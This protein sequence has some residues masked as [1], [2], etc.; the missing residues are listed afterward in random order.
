MNY[1]PFHI[2]DYFS[3]TRHLSWE[4][5][6]A[7]RR[8]LDVYYRDERPIPSEIPAACRLILAKT[9]A[10]RH[11]VETVLNEFFVLSE[12]GW[13]N[14][15]ADAEIMTMQGRQ[16]VQREKAN[17]RW[18]QARKAM[19]QH[20]ETDAAAYPAA[21]PAA[22]PPTPTPTPEPEPTPKPVPPRAS[23]AGRPVGDLTETDLQRAAANRV[24]EKLHAMGFPK[25]YAADE[26]LLKL[27]AA[28][29]TEEDFIYA[30][31]KAL[32]KTN[33][34]KYL[35]GTVEGERFDADWLRGFTNH[36]REPGQGPKT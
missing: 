18:D 27:L 20:D 5:D 3:T 35:L 36:A 30:A 15:R 31:P 13:T 25:V 6:C 23:H 24:C 1:Y 33:P 14:R 22:M 9:K 26:K 8:L 11:A 4:E 29:A 19:S 28:G 34:F 17:K 10:Q 12:S 2:G 32:D 7:Y 16:Q 21:Y